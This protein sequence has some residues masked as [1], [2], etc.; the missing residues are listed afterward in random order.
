MVLTRL[1]FSITLPLKSAE[2]VMIRPVFNLP[3]E[4]TSRTGLI[5]ECFLLTQLTAAP[6]YPEAQFPLGI[7]LLLSL[8][9]AEYKAAVRNLVVLAGQD[10][11][12]LAGHSARGERHAAGD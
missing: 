4:T 6:D 8:C 3:T 1:L 5:E 7:P 9:I 10:I 2:N 11:F 12:P